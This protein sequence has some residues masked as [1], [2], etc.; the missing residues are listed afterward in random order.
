MQ[1][2]ARRP[3]NRGTGR[4]VIELTQADALVPHSVVDGFFDAD[5]IE[6][7][8]GHAAAVGALAAK[9]LAHA[10]AGESTF[11]ATDSGSR[12][13]IRM[14]RRTGRGFAQSPRAGSGG[15]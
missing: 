9:A 10:Y 5:S 6:R 13:T 7:P 3:Q 14:T 1:M 4:L 2:V 8:G 12:L 11:E 15:A